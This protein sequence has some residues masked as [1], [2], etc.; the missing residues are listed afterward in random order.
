M[1][2]RPPRSTRADPHVPY[3][4]LVRSRRTA[5]RPQCLRQARITL[6]EL[7]QSGAQPGGHNRSL[8]EHRPRSSPGRGRCGLPFLTRGVSRETWGRGRDVPALPFFLHYPLAGVVTLVI[9]GGQTENTAGVSNEGDDR[10]GYASQGPG[11]RPVRR[12]A[13]EHDPRSEEHTSE[14]QSLMR[15]SYAVFCL[16]KKTRASTSQITT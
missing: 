15:I 8:P 14:L 10:T 2:R 9:T 6:F 3:T 7:Q 12:G 5:V 16:K 11:A 4:T 13:Q 1:L